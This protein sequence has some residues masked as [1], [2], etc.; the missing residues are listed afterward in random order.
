M[1]VKKDDNLK[2]AGKW[3]IKEKYKKDDVWKDFLYAIR[4]MSMEV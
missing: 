1:E 4:N 3:K 2:K